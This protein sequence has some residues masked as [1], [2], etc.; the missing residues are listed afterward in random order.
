MTHF[1]NADGERGVAEQVAAFERGAEGCRRAQ[2]VEFGGHAAGI[3]N[4]HS[5]WVRPGI[6]LYGASPSGGRPRAGTACCRP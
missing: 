6:M 3:P 2:P 1:A 5:D 4:A